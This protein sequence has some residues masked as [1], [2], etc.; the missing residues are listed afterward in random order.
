MKSI[1]KSIRDEFQRSPIGTLGAIAAV[2]ALFVANPEILNVTNTATAEA[3]PTVRN[4]A[5]LITWILLYVAVCYL[6]AKWGSVVIRQRYSTGFLTYPVFSVIVVTL[7]VY[8]ASVYLGGFPLLEKVHPTGGNVSHSWVGLGT[9][10]FC[11]ILVS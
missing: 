8:L 2:L 9:P 4:S 11:F 3:D 5:G 6:F 10:A 1:L 7:G